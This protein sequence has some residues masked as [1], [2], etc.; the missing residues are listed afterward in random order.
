M[1]F[2]VVL[3]NWILLMGIGVIV[4]YSFHTLNKSIKGLSST[5]L[6]SSKTIEMVCG[7]QEIHA[8]IIRIYGDRLER[9][10]KWANNLTT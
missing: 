3:T 5:V 7:T 4:F 10:E 2:A 8:D 1:G 9:L 6:A